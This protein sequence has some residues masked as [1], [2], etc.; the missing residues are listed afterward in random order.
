[1]EMFYKIM[2]G[3]SQTLGKQSSFEGVT[4]LEET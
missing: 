4:D 1:M 2:V 3:M